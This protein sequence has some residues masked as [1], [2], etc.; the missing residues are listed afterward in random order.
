MMDRLDDLIEEL[1][2]G[3][4]LSAEAHNAL[5]GATS[6]HPWCKGKSLAQRKLEVLFATA[7]RQ[8]NR[9]ALHKIERLPC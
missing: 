9:V 7:G 5:H 6:T 3:A 1:K 8:V 2:D 4:K